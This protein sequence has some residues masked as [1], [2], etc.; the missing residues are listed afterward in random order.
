MC[1]VGVC[2]TVKRCVHACMFA[3]RQCDTVVMACGAAECAL[4]WVSRGLAG[5]VL[6]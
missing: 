6:T 3:A 5:T 1:G 4:Q 2:V